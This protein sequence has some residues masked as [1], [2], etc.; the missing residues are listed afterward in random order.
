MIGRSFK[1]DLSEVSL[2][3]IL[4]LLRVSNKTGVL[5]LRQDRVKKSLHI[6]D[7]NVVFALS[8]L[9]EERLGDLLLSRKLITQVQYD[10]SVAMLSSKKRQGRILVEMGAIT[11]K[12][13]WEGV[14]DQIRQ[15]VYS[16]FNWTHG[17]FYFAEGE[18]PG[19]ENITADVGIT[20]LIVEGIRRIQD[21]KELHYR[22]PSQGVILAQSEP[23]S[24]SIHLEPFEKH[25]LEL[26]NGKRTLQQICTES[27]IGDS[28][29]LKV[30]YML[31]SVGYIK[32]KGG[33]PKKVPMEKEIST[34]EA[35]AIIGNYNRMFSYL[36]RYMMREVGP[37]AEHV[38]AKYLMEL[39]EA[40]ASILKNVQLKKDGTLDVATIQGNLNWIRNDQKRDLLLAS[41]NEFLYSSILA[42]K[43]T[44]GP[45]H[46]SRVIETLKDIRPEL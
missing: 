19:Q 46:E 20:D 21:V 7:G 34:D 23:Q 26:V 33:K 39:K 43:R 13:L 22:F 27:E 29:T 3:D 14:Q 41:L 4:E 42:V 37:I 40:N 31:L 9:P 38:L 28:Q 6:Q 30:L 2:P 35:T 45:E 11:P 5:T 16:L 10:Q 18:L 15:I 32:A 44:L 1:G 36:Y 12:Q 8:N 24:I 17:M 25:V